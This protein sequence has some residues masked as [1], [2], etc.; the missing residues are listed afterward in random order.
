MNLTVDS[1]N[2]RCF[3]CRYNDNKQSVNISVNIEIVAMSIDVTNRS[4]L[5]V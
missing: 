5:Y 1:T 2:K 4:D 3:F